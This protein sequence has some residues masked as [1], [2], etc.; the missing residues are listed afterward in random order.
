M[1]RSLVAVRGVMF[2]TLALFALTTSA[3]AQN[4]KAK[5]T[6]PRA[7]ASRDYPD[8]ASLTAMHYRYIGPEGNRTDAVAGVKGDPNIYY[9]GA[10]SG[11]L[12]KTIDA[13]AHWNPIFDDQ[14]AQS[15]GAIT[16]APSDANVVW[17]GTGE[18]FIRSH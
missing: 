7:A 8:T 12:W 18:S 2:T 11:G 9:A 3:S 1:Q 15:I 17:V 13:G 16:V 14:P 6:A 10:A 4:K 5:S